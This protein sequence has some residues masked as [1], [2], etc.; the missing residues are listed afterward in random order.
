MIYTVVTLTL[1]ALLGNIAIR[2]QYVTGAKP[3]RGFTRLSHAGIA[4]VAGVC[5]LLQLA[6]GDQEQLIF[7]PATFRPFGTALS[8]PATTNIVPLVL[9]GCVGII[10]LLRISRPFTGFDR[11][12]LF[13]LCLLYMPLQYTFGLSELSHAFPGVFQSGLV[14]LNLLM[15]AL[16]LVLAILA[17]FPLPDQMAWI[18][19]LPLFAV[20]VGV[21]CLQG[22]L[23]DYE[24]F[25]ALSSHSQQ[26]VDSVPHLALFGQVVFFSLAV[27]IALLFIGVI[28]YLRAPVSAKWSSTSTPANTAR[29]SRIASAADRIGILGVALGCGA[30][31][32]AFWQGMLQSAPP[33][34]ASA[35]SANSLY[36]PLL[37]LGVGYTVMGISLLTT[38][39]VAVS[40]L[41]NLSQTYPRL[42]GLVQFLDRVTVL[43]ITI[44]GLLLFST[45]GNRGGWLA[46]SLNLGQ[47][48][49][50]GASSAPA[51]DITIHYSLILMILIAL[52]G[53]IAFF[54][55]TRAFGR[56]ERVLLLLCGA[57]TM[58]MLTD[59]LDV[60]QL[61]LFSANMHQAAGNFFSSLNADQVVALS[62][63]IAA[64]LSFAWLLSTTL[65]SDRLALGLVFGL[66]ALLA[67]IAAV[68]AQQAPVI[69]AFIVMMQGVLI[70]AKV[71]RVRRGNVPNAQP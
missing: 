64:L 50:S 25:S 36:A 45:F 16:P 28:F 71:E 68:P 59:T 29:A 5:F 40:A 41:F 55:L 9:L 15:L 17:F 65:V 34:F 26:V 14:V 47:G 23:G 13:T 66:V 42:A 58:L 22:F 30:V 53:L 1:I 62:L 12:M 46:N 18:R 35:Q 8:L 57:G 11:V 33:L 69:L 6:F 67:L 43:G 24:P 27:A 48:T 61:P 19:L 4:G 20:S 63:L 3:A 56:A 39:I 10:S 2:K 60:Q 44:I 49:S 54:R 21:A 32:W 38:G 37:S 31:Q 51:S 7:F 52:F 70:A